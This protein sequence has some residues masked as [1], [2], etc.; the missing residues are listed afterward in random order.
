MHALEA[1]L[2]PARFFRVSR[3]AIV[4]LDRVVELQPYSRGAMVVVLRDG[5]RIKLSRS[6][7]PELEAILGQSL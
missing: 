3:S 6:R 5:T 7:V 1:R 4:N 2:D